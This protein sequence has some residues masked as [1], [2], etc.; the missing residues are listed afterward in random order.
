MHQRSFAVAYL[1]DP[2]LCPSEIRCAGTHLSTRQPELG[3]ADQ[4]GEQDAGDGSHGPATVDDLGISEVL[5][6]VGVGAQAQGV[7]AIVTAVSAWQPREQ[8]ESACKLCPMMLKPLRALA[9]AA[10]LMTIQHHAGC[11]MSL[12]AGCRSGGQG[13]WL[14]W[15]T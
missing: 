1:L 15:H 3:L 13:R 8:A 9:V 10:W 4:V 14:L 5:Q 7:E 2:L 12:T 11:C 6:G